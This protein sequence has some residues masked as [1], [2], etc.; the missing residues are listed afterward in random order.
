MDLR[1]YKII[2]PIGSG[3]FGN[4]YKCEH[5]KSGKLVAIKVPINIPDKNTEKLLIEESKIYS[6]IS[7]PERGI[8]NVSTITHKGTKLV[9][10]D[11]LGESLS[12]LMARHKKFGLK[13]VLYI[14]IETI[15]ILR[16]IHSKGYLHRD[17]KPDN[18]TIGYGKESG[19]IYCIDF[20]LSKAYLSKGGEH[21]PEETAK[22]FVGTARYASISAHKGKTQG[23]KD[24]LE[25]L[26][27]L[28]IFFYKGKLPWQGIK[29]QDKAKRLSLIRKKKE[30]VSREVLCHGLPKEFL[31]YFEYIDSLEYADKPKY[32]S[33]ISLFTNLYKSIGYT[34]NVLEWEQKLEAG[35]KL[36]SQAKS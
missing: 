35:L 8:C 21:I 7:N 34:D 1:D 11:L 15:K 36:A 12:V 10:M 22:K 5:K 28:L 3:S 32:T 17:L 9:V 13:T 6:K 18:F 27:Y 4:V 33:L 26:G 31:V 20:G 30:S 23:R 29:T 25:A 14:G 2:E 19:K 24:D 16:W